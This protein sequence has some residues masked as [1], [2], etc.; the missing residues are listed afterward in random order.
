MM[1]NWS[2]ALAAAL[3]LPVGSAR[4]GPMLGPEVE[5]PPS[6]EDLIFVAEMGSEPYHHFGCSAI[7]VPDVRSPDPAFTGPNGSACPGRLSAT[8]DF[9]LVVSG[10]CAPNP[11]LYILRRDGPDWGQWAAETVPFDRLV[12]AGAVAIL[13]DNETLLLGTTPQP[14]VD[15]PTPPPY[16]V[17]K[18]LLS[19]IT[20]EGGEWRMGPSRGTIEVP[21][22]A[23]EILAAPDGTRAHIL[24]EY[25]EVLTID[26]H[27]MT[28]VA[29]RIALAPP[30]RP[31]SAPKA[32]GY[33]IGAIQATLSG[34][35]LSGGNSRVTG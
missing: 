25:G 34:R 3:L 12:A 15:W 23:A 33:V 27:T 7:S 24:T 35:S 8:S 1:R 11:R 17:E 10:S 4:A 18:F 2:V 32:G 16:T 19:E 5:S 20:D 31:G 9:S 30:I 26:P 28:E 21:S 6:L 14:Q 29:P 22:L 13:L